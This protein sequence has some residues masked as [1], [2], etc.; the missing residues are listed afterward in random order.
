LDSG[1]QVA[2]LSFKGAVIKATRHVRGA[3]RERDG[4]IKGNEHEDNDLKW[5]LAFDHVSVTSLLT[6][7]LYDDFR[8]QCCSAQHDF[9]T[10]NYK[11]SFRA[12]LLVVI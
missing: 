1:P 7:G 6:F 12:N 11:H 5:A 4:V 2:N 9:N 8:V 3:I 10:V